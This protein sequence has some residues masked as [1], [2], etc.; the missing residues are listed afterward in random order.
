[1]LFEGELP[2]LNSIRVEKFKAGVL[3]P[4]CNRMT[5][6]EDIPS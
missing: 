5:Y 1:M 6:W 4:L 2:T 3:A